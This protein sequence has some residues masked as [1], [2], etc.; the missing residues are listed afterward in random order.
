MVFR[1]VRSSAAGRSA[2]WIVFVGAVGIA[3]CSGESGA[4]G[5]S[6]KDG[7]NG[8]DGKD[9][10][11]CTVADNGDGTMTVACPDGTTAI[12]AKSA[13]GATGADGKSSLVTVTDASAAQ[14]AGG[15]KI[16][17]V[18]V[19]DGAGGGIA[20]DGI[21]Q[22]G[23]VDSTT[24]LC[25]GEGGATGSDGHKAL[26]ALTDASA[27]DCPAGGKVLHSG[28]DDGDGGG[29][30]DDGILQPGEVD[31]TTPICNGDSGASG[32]TSLV[33]V[34]NATAAQC[35]AGG[36]V[37]GV[38]IDN[39]DGGGV[40][41]DGIL[42][43]GE[44]DSSTPVCNGGSC[45]L[46]NDGDGTSTLLCDDGTSTTFDSGVYTVVDLGLDSGCGIRGDG[47][48]ACWGS[49]GHGKSTPP[50]GAFRQ[51]SVG[52]DHAC[53][54]RTNGAVACWGNIAA[55]PAGTFT[56]VSVGGTASN[57]AT[58]A[59]GLKS[60]GTI[61]CWGNTLPGGVYTPP[62]TGTLVD[63][64]M[65]NLW[66]CGIRT[67]QTLTCW[68]FGD[69]EK[70]APAGTFTKVSA[71]YTHTCALRT[72]G[73]AAC[74][75]WFNLTPPAGTFTDVA[76]GHEFSCG[77]RTGTGNIVCWGNAQPAGPPPAGPFVSVTG[78]HQVACGV[79][80]DGSVTCWGSNA[81]NRAT[82]PAFP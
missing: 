16:I 54:V 52:A 73:T 34:T 23:E 33:S 67:N 32:Y 18:G 35:P 36:K 30:A 79:R 56:R 17:Q 66:G 40:A 48:L 4:D 57:T 3:A 27:H 41:G 50:S 59:C 78:G 28:S 37:I 11:S 82:P 45:R 26:V 1:R 5:S 53:A 58:A 42:Q 71:S 72:D 63:L 6:G 80:T 31:V 8:A 44:V 39:G 14:C 43:T 81:D 10:R 29:I 76:A 46:W 2:A 49:N 25:H 75:G 12:V 61:A 13:G 47:S 68:G 77:V 74:W 62:P 19:D 21:L 55:P 60:D 65:G 22:P 70:N 20:G 24:P 51:V 69:G 7:V 15:G 64:G 9:G 38:G